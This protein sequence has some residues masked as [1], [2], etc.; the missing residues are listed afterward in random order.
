MCAAW[1]Q[2]GMYDIHLWTG[3]NRRKPAAY[4]IRETR[5]KKITQK[6][7]R[8]IIIKSIEKKKINTYANTVRRFLNVFLL[9]LFFF[10]F[11]FFRSDTIIIHTSIIT[12]THDRLDCINHST[13]IRVINFLFTH[14]IIW[15]LNI[16]LKKL[17]RIF[18]LQ[19][20]ILYYRISYSIRGLDR[21]EIIGNTMRAGTVILF[22]PFL[23]NYSFSL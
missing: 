9:L 17:Y 11:F 20:A 10:S 5:R 16:Y 23:R 14:V 15:R 19:R 13:F 8:A 2:K 12:T 4:G 3:K 21:Y 7:C 22:V 6:T 18:C 1:Y